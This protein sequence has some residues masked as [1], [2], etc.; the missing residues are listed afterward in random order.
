[1][2]INYVYNQENYMDSITP[3]TNYLSMQLD[4]YENNCNIT[5]SNPQAVK[6]SLFYLTGDVI[7]TFVVEYQV[8]C[9]MSLFHKSIQ[10]NQNCINMMSQSMHL[11]LCIVTHS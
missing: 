1:M 10:I 4:H 7:T 8:N 2:K 3:I 5:L 9:A 6:V 11:V